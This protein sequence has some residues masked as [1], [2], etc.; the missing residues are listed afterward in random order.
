MLL[1]DTPDGP[2]AS[3][4]EAAG[5]SSRKLFIFDPSLR[6]GAGH[7]SINLGDLIIRDA[8]DRV[9]R[10]LFPG[11]TPMRV[12]THDY[13]SPEQLAAAAEAD[14]VVV[15]GT[16]LLSSDLLRYDQWKLSPDP[17]DYADP[18]CLDAVL[19]G[20]GWW[21]YQ[22]RPDLVTRHYYRR[23]LHPHCPQS[24]RDDYS[25][26]QLAACG[27]TAIR[28]TSCPTLWGLDGLETA[29]V[30]GNRRCLFCLTDYAPNPEADD[31]LVRQLAR[32]YPDGLVFFPQ[33]DHDLEYAA[34]LSTF[35]DLADHIE[36]LPHVH[37]SFLSLLERGQE[38]DYVGTRLHAGAWC[39]EHRLPSLILA[40]DN[41]AAEIS[42][43]TGLPVVARGDEAA[44]ARWHAGQ[45][46]GVIR[47]PL[48]DIAAWK[49]AICETVQARLV[50]RLQALPAPAPSRLRLL[51]LGCGG[52][53]HPDWVNMDMTAT[54][55]GVMAHDLT[56]PLP[57]DEGAFD[58]VYASH[59]LEHFS[60][61]QAGRFLEE[62][63]RVLRP[64]GIL[65][66]AVPDLEWLARR[67]LLALE[68]AAAGF[69]PEAEARHEYAVINLVDQLCRHVSGGEMLRFWRRDP[70]PAEDYVLETNGLEVL[71][72]LVS[73]RMPPPPPESAEL[74]P[75]ARPWW[76]GLLG[77]K[78]GPAQPV[79]VAESPAE[80]VGRFRLSGESHLWMYDRV[81]LRRLFVQAGFTD[82][83]R[84]QADT[85]GIDGFVQFDLDTDSQGQPYKP[86]SLYLEGKRPVDTA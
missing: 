71:R 42:R 70:L 35:A 54:L 4:A 41:R 17:L 77:R 29:R 53:A 55:P 83:A 86:E 31:R 26:G 62:C 60:R 43:D 28:N 11:V 82:I 32:L 15:A 3:A 39:L 33:G 22:G 1:S 72:A 24:V 80:S 10:E 50:R 84:H 47:L 9:W 81:S 65:R 40:V 44:L 37:E 66:L 61:D 79:S 25:V 57:F 27:L 56:Q 5:K 2:D 20:V 78:T 7:P 46:R 19:C 23:L 45:T 68:D 48:E 85:S 13:P 59:V 6:D 76:R 63:W 67:Y 36:F 52:R 12:A 58:A 69:A 30:S 18:P 8:C 49:E 16:N 38:L 51:N 21:Q 34:S 14:L 74:V 73:I 64:G 75:L